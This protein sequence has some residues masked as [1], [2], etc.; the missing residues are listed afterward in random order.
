[1]TPPPPAADP[2]ERV[3][4]DGS[5]AWRWPAGADALRI[6]VEGARPVRPT[7][8][9]D[10][11]WSRMR[12][13]NPRLFDGPILAVDRFGPGEPI[14]CR[15][16][17]Y[18]RLAVQPRVATGVEQL[19]VTAL[20]TGRD[21]HGVERAL[22]GRRGMT[23]RIYGGMWELAPAGGLEPA[24]GGTGVLT[25]ADVQTQLLREAHEE[26]ETGTEL[27]PGEVV[28]AVRDVRAC[29]LDLVIACGVKE[30]GGPTGD[31]A[32]SSPPG[33]ARSWEYAG[34]AW[35]SR[36]DVARLLRDQPPSVIAPTR[37]VLTLLGWGGGA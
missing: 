24:P 34:V 7:P 17:S 21:R 30:G 8:D 11:E 22:L 2:P 32:E 28:A 16:D 5:I 19:S 20:V 1:M 3:E 6:V 13:A 15:S 14:R 33:E 35:P 4:V 27:I 12:A 36:D 25:L 18:K 9:V 26:L 29:S 31:G 10:A 23:T 37:A